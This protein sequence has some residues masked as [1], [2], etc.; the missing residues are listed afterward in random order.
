MRRAPEPRRRSGGAKTSARAARN[1]DTCGNPTTTQIVATGSFRPN[2]F[3][4]YDTSGNAAEWVEDCW[5]DNYR[6]HPRTA[7]PGPRV[8]ARLRVLRGGNF[9]SKAADERSA[10]R[11]R[12]DVDVRHHANGFRIVRDLQ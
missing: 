12:Y 8:I 4:L 5:N 1:A 3:G 7:P 2:G 6:A 10:S 9:L 11:F